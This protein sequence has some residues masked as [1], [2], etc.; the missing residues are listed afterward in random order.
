MWIGVLDVCSC[1]L[2]SQ[3]AAEHAATKASSGCN[4]RHALMLLH[5]RMRILQ[6]G[7]RLG[8]A[9]HDGEPVYPIAR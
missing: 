9:T 5:V 8:D 1:V 3:P 4:P 7:E 2:T 6:R